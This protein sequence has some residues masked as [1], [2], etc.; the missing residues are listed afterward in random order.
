[1]QQMTEANGIELC[2]ET[3]GSPSRP[4]L[5]LV[6]GYTAQMTGW[7]DGFCQALA[8]RG[9]YVIRFD[10]RDVGLSSKS[11]GPVPDVMALMGKLRQ[12][13]TVSPD[14]TPYNLSDMAADAIG[15]LDALDIERAH[16]VGA[17]MGG[18]IVQHLAFDHQ[19]RVLSATSIMSTTGDSDVGQASEEALGALL[20]PAPANRDEFIDQSVDTSRVISGPLW[21]EADARARATAAYDRMYH[22]TG[23][24]FQMAAIVASGNRTDRLKEVTIPFGVIH[25]R[26]DQLIDV[27]GGH[28]TADAVEGAEL[29]LFDEMGHDLP[30][31]LWPDLIESIFATA[32]RAEIL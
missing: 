30:P 2:Y 21:V 6:M 12:G 26:V 5:L 3:F 29:V 11:D 20:R 17:S 19:E 16:V 32:E 4:P 15:L 27:S 10:N 13:G 7:H 25:G 9:T 31:A 18:M 22:P 14:E 23:A 8:D 1:M 24:A 28:A